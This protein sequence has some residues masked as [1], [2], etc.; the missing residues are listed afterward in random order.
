MTSIATA[1][2]DLSWDD[3]ATRTIMQDAEIAVLR[4]RLAIAI[5]GLERGPEHAATALHTLRHLERVRPMMEQATFDR[6][7]APK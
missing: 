5:D 2:T 4:S 6:E 3:L 7:G 1:A